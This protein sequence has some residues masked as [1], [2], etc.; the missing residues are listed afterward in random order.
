MKYCTKCGTANQDSQNFC[1]TCGAALPASAPNPGYAPNTS[2]GQP[3]YSNTTTPIN[4]NVNSA[5]QQPITEETLPEKFRPIKPW[6]YVGY[7]LLFALPLIGLIMMIVY[8]TK[9]DNINR[10][11]YARSFLWMMLLAIAISLVVSLVFGATFATV[12]SNL[13][14]Y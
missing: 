1:T 5:Y 2:Y 14:Y 12:F 13:N 11:N 9:D 4:F 7:S 10:R 6:G 8:A 3:S